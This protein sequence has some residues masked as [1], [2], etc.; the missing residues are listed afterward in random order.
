MTYELTLPGVYQEPVVR[1]ADA[2][3]R[4]DVAGFIGFERRV[5]DGSTPCA[6]VPTSGPPLGH[7][8]QVDVL[9]CELR[10]PDTKRRLRVPA[11]TDL[12]L[13]QAPLSIPQPP[14]GSIC[15]AII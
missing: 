13:S 1:S 3:P 7:T 12:V 11:T 15:Y 8:Y 2:M 4:T 5:R 14:G 9:S 10:V 6:L